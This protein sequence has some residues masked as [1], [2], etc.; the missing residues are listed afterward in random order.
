MNMIENTEL[1]NTFFDTPERLS[2]E[3]ILKDILHFKQNSLLNQLLEGFPE[4]AVIIN[5][6][7]QIVAFNSKA[8]ET[9]RVEDYFYIVGKRI[10]EA[11]N[12]IHS[13]ELLSGCGTSHFCKECGAAQAIKHTNEKETPATNECRISVEVDGNIIAYDLLVQTQPIFFED[14][15]YTVFAIK[16]ISSNKRRDALEKIFFHDIL[17]TAGAIKGL[18]EILPELK[19]EESKKEITDAVISSSHQLLNEINAQRTLK[20]AEDGR[21]KPDFV[22]TSSNKILEGVSE[23]YENYSL[24]NNRILNI[25]YSESDVELCTDISLIIRSLSNLVKNAL[26]NS[27]ANEEVTVSFEEF[28]DGIA[29][30]VCNN[31]VIPEEIQLQLFHR[32]FSTKR[33]KG[34]GIGLYSVKLIVEQYLKG[35]VNFISNDQNKTVFTIVLP[36]DAANDFGILL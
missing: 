8:L 27:A 15:T 29:F 18:A 5:K 36:K 30:H 21:L 25:K 6:N 10:G 16:D 9:F 7:R 12:C 32:S 3:E 13:A 33:S 4:L 2:N 17:N 23:L 20:N 14:K 34:H 35:K 22:H 31:K 28:N 26:E 19:D 24:N 1:I 11:F